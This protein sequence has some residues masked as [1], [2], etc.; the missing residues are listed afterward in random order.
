M[1]LMLFLEFRILLWWS[2]LYVNND[3]PTDKRHIC[4]ADYVI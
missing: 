4:E 2:W 3:P 1:N